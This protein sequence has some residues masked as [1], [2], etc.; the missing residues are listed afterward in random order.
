MG[1]MTMKKMCRILA[2][3]SILFLTACTASNN[4]STQTTSTSV[5]EQKKETPE[6]EKTV[7]LE[8]TEALHAY[9]ELLD[10]ID[11]YDFGMGD[12]VSDHVTYGI[13][14]LNHDIPQLIVEKFYHAQFIGVAKIF[15]Y[16]PKTQTCIASDAVFQIDNPS[17]LKS[18]TSETYGWLTLLQD[19]KGLV[20]TENN[21]STH[22]I[23]RCE[24]LTWEDNQLIVK[25]ITKMEF[26]SLPKEPKLIT[27]G[28]NDRRLLE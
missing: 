4:R 5:T 6:P 26:N 14:Y 18:S 9:N 23:L 19:H 28:I 16:D 22:E 8:V 20:Y 3:V 1:G 27:L 2:C 24:L 17:E 10:N 15:G 25:E 21:R 11:A 13:V 12:T 7:S